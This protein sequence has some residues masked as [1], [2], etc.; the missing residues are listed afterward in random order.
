MPTVGRTWSRNY[1]ISSLP[2]QSMKPMVYN[3]RFS[4]NK[5]NNRSEVNLESWEEWA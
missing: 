2:K 1:I 4:I 3:F 5:I